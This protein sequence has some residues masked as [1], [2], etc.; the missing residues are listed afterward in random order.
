MSHETLPPIPEKS[1]FMCH[2]NFYPKSKIDLKDLEI[3]TLLTKQ[4]NYDDIVSKHSTAIRLTL[5]EEMTAGADPNLPLVTNKPYPLPLKYY[6]FVKEEI[7]KFI[8]SMTNRSMSPYA[9]PIIVLPR[10]CKLVAPLAEMKRLVIDY[11]QLSKKISKVQTIQAKSK[12]SLAL[13]DHIWSKLKDVKYFPLLDICSGYHHFS[14]HPDSRPKAAFT[15]PY[16]K[17]Q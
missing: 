5:L 3:E 9:A 15:C 8:R 6:M 1:A 17:F 10:K 12:G 4:Q 11:H 2:H 7:K 14:I 16:R 13:I